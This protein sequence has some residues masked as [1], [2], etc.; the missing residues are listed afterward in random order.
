M[1]PDGSGG[2]F[3]I[4]DFV[5]L[6]ERNF[7]SAGLSAFANWSAN[8]IGVGTAERLQGMRVSANAFA[9]LGVDPLAGRTFV[10]ADGVEGRVVMLGHA[11]WSRRFGA[12][13]AIVGRVLTLNDTNYTVVGVL[14]K[15]FVFPVRDAEFAVPIV[16]AD[17]RRVEGDVNFL[18]L[19]ARLA[20]GVAIARAEQILTAV[21]VS[22]PCSWG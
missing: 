1:R 21:A 19:I 10:P 14:P 18:R 17:A 8:L 2:P 5:D 7:G 4:Q 9:V 6:R 3:S 15:S 16:E 20:P 13:A 22:A 12:D 11:L